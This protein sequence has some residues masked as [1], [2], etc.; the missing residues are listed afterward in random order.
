MFGFQ[1]VSSFITGTVLHERT[2]DATVAG[3]CIVSR[4]R[5]AVCNWWSDLW[6]KDSSLPGSV[7]IV[8]ECNQIQILNND[9]Y[10]ADNSNIVSIFIVNPFN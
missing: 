2:G 9:Y 7:G 4:R 3:S 8:L 5:M 1:C 10:L 6:W